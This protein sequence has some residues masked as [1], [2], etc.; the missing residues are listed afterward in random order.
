MPAASS[1]RAWATFS[2]ASQLYVQKVRDAVSEMF[3]LEQTVALEEL[4]Q[5][6]SYHVLEVAF[7]ETEESIS[8]DSVRAETQ[9]VMTLHGRLMYKEEGHRCE[10]VDLVM[11]SAFLEDT[12]AE[13]LY[14]AFRRRIPQWV[15]FVASLSK[16]FT[17][18]VNSD[19]GPSCL[20]LARRLGQEYAV[21]SAPCRMHQ[22]CLA[23]NSVSRSRESWGR[24]FARRCF[25]AEG[26]SKACSGRP[27][28]VTWL[29][30]SKSRGDRQVP[31]FEGIRLRSSTCSTDS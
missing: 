30:T 9:H 2:G 3:M 7:D 8:V 21:I 14:E 15:R 18:I 28:K 19:S 12:K 22:G 20:R 16:N 29:P 10:K 27:W 24:S 5:R 6:L 23:M 4:S 31:R 26:A 11:P 25:C 17:I 1:T 13:T